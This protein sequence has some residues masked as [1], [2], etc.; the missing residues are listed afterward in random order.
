MFCGNKKNSLNRK[1]FCK[2]RRS[3]GFFRFT[4]YCRSEDLENLVL[5]ILMRKTVR[6]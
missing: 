5:R 6:G 4:L 2:S 3:T 1:V